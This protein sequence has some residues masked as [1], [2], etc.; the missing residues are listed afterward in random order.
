MGRRRTA[1]R[2][3]CA[4]NSSTALVSSSTNSGTPSVRS[5]I[6]SMIS[7]GSAA[8]PATFAHQRRASR[9]GRAASARASSHAAARSRA[10]G[11]RAGTSRP[12]AP[13]TAA[14]RSIVRSSSSREVGSIQWTSS[15]TISTGCRRPALRS[16]AAAPRTSSPSCAAAAEV[17]RWGEIS[18]G[19]DSRSRD[20]RHVFGRRRRGGASSAWSLPSLASG[21]S[22]AREAGGA[23][24]LGDDRI[25]RAVLMVRRAE[26]AQPSMR[27]RRRCAPPAPR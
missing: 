23:F 9:A 10:A 11:I 17:K 8:L 3:L 1:A 19:S 22:V 6:S 27:S 18:C 4:P 13:A 12:A 5:T 21:A 16:G 25:E 26:I 20:Q 7:G 14:T 24:E 15:N 2:A